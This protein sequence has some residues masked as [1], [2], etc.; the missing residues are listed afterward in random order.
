MEFYNLLS[1]YFQENTI[2]SD[3]AS[4][5]IQVLAK[6]MYPITPHI[7]Y[8]VLLEFD[9]K[10]PS[11]PKWPEKFNVTDHDEEIQ[12]IIQINGKLRSKLNVKLGISKTEVI[13]LA[14]KDNKVL[15]LIK[16]KNIIKVI[17]VSN[18][19]VNFVIK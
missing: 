18:K 6:L 10:H 16:D 11:N 5:C 1:K 8:A 3:V 9:S 15:G 13:K 12:I 19:L 14:E 4:Q 7:C 2:S 17:Y